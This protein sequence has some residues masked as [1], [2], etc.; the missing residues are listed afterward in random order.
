MDEEQFP[1]LGQSEVWANTKPMITGLGTAGSNPTHARVDQAVRNIKMCNDD[2]TLPYNIDFQTT[3]GH[4][5][6]SNRIW[7]EKAGVPASCF[8]DKQP[9][10]RP[11]IAGTH[12]ETGASMVRAS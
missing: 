3:F 11:Y 10:C 2:G 12:T 4:E 1:R 7:L 5:S 6:P 9:V 8:L